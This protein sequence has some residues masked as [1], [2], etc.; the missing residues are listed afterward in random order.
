MNEQGFPS[1]T[2]IGAQIKT[3]RRAPFYALARWYPYLR[4][5]RKNEQ[6]EYVYKRMSKDVM[7]CIMI[8][9]NICNV[10][11]KTFNNISSYHSKSIVLVKVFLPK[12]SC[13]HSSNKTS[14]KDFR[15]SHCIRKWFKLGS[16]LICFNS[17]SLSF[18]AKLQWFRFDFE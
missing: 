4:E 3:K 1:L 2:S 13:R 6:P 9:G 7:K 18:N 5:E 8:I 16:N 15:I 14:S 11:R 12:F 17:I 10:T